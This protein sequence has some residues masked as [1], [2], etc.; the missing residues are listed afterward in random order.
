MSSTKS[1]LCR[2]ITTFGPSGALDED[3]FRDHLARL[4]ENGI[5][6]FLGSSGSGEGASL[7]PDELDRVYRIGVEVCKGKVPVNSNQPERFTADQTIEQARIAMA[8][9]VDALNIYGPNG[10]D[11]YAATEREYLRYFDRVLGAIDFS[12]TLCPNLIIGYAPQPATIAEIANRHH[13]V[14]GIL[15][16][17][18]R[19][20][21]F[22]FRSLR[23]D[24]ARDVPIW[25]YPPG[26]FEELRLGAAGLDHP[27][28]NLIPKTCRR[29]IDALNAGDD[30]AAH[31]AD[32]EIRRVLEFVDQWKGALR[33]IKA[34][35]QV[36]RLPGWQ[37]GMREPYFVLEGDELT[38]F[39]RGL[40]SLGIQEIDDL[41]AA[42]ATN[43]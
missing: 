5:G 31:A 15:L 16:S 12:V 41:A 3:A 17:D 13:Q 14:A 43:T 27:C 6:V 30:D 9:G 37:G 38:R 32:A 29:L 21:G 7:T 35:I 28:P 24:L 25:V 36:L 34:A 18:L 8:A 19:D 1:F 40:L 2:T 4:V 22:Y 20:G 10:L 42:S 11:G 26:A 39:R 23:G 33:W